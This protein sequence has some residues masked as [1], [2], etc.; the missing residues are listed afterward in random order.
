MS[1]TDIVCVFSADAGPDADELAQ[2]WL[3]E[4]SDVA[5]DVAWYVSQVAA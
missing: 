4:Q 2:E 5:E 3:D 1:Y